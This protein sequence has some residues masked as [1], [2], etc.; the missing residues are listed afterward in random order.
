MP[1]LEWTNNRT[2][3]RTRTYHWLSSIRCLTTRCSQFSFQYITYQVLSTCGCFNLGP[4]NN[5]YLISLMSKLN[6]S[7]F[8][9][10]YYTKSQSAA[11]LLQLMIHYGKLNNQVQNVW[12]LRKWLKN[13]HGNFSIDLKSFIWLKTKS[14]SLS[15]TYLSG[16][17]I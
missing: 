11:V 14:L 7:V 9:L 10:I 8:C 16:N 13:T 12:K 3:E 4:P 1:I 2:N 17:S 5:S 6:I 15:V